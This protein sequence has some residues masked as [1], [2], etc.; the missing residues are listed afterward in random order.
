M[1]DPYCWVDRMA[2]VQERVMFRIEM[3]VRELA[4]AASVDLGR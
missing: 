4:Q 2:A 3:K 1:C